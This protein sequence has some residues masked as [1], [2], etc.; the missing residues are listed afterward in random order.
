MKRILG[1]VRSVLEKYHI[2]PSFGEDTVFLLSAAIVAITLVDREAW[3]FAELVRAQ[4]PKI[5]LMILL[6]VGFSIYTALFTS[7]KNE[8]QKFYIFWLVVIANF[9]SAVA[10]IVILGESTHAPY[11][12][13]VPSVNIL[14]SIALIVLW[15]ADAID[16]SCMSHKSATFSKVVYGLLFLLLFIFSAEYIWAVPWPAV[17]SGAVGYATLFNRKF[18]GRLPQL[19][20]NRDLRTAEIESTFNRSVEHVIQSLMNNRHFG[21]SIVTDSGVKDS[22]IPTEY[23]SNLDVYLGEEVRKL[24]RD[25]MSVG[26]ATVGKYRFNR[27]WFL[28]PREEMAVIVDVYPNDRT[29]GHQFCQMFVYNSDGEIE[30]HKGVIYLGRIKNLYSQ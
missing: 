4:S 19:L 16:L 11:W 14:A 15:Y 8:I 9:L 1:S 25:S 3:V 24:N 18:T 29:Q 17:L 27:F 21:V 2:L 23:E 20:K 7:F 6:G 10:S 13:L 30:L 22:E 26:V 5:Y 28:P 12:Y